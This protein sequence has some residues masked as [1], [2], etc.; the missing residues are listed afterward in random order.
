MTIPAT[1]TAA[2][3]VAS[4]PAIQGLADPNA[5]P[6]LSAMKQAI[7]GMQ[8]RR[9]NQT[10]I[11]TLGASASLGDVIQKVNAILNRIQT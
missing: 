8:G 9:P 7:E 11:A 2:P 5:V 10:K 3:I 1:T 4:I 6:I